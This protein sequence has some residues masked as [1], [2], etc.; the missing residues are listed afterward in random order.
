MPYTLVGVNSRLRRNRNSGYWP[1]C[2]F[3]S[4][5]CAQLRLCPMHAKQLA[6]VV[7][8]CLRRVLGAM[9]G[10]LARGVSLYTTVQFVHC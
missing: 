10:S 4:L 9:L 3:A 8:S 7:A 5:P 6:V 1:V 2:Q